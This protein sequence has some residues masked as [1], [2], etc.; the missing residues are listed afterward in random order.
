MSAPAGGPGGQPT[1]VDAPAPDT[2]LVS[3]S[4]VPPATTTDGPP[5][6]PAPAPAPGSFAVVAVVVAVAAYLTYGYLTM[7]VSE[8]SEGPGPRFFPGIVLV[9]AWGVAVGLAVDAVRAR[10][11]ARSGADRGEDEHPDGP[12][13]TDWRAVGTVTAVFAVFVVALVP[14]GWLLS[15][16]FLFWGVAQALGSRRRLF[17]AGVGLAISSVVQLVF[18]AVLGLGL[19]AGLLGVG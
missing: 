9:V 14:L 12:A 7:P 11:R 6:R 10:R 8:G 1:P 18:G 2:A 15:G 16:A 17:D 19:P 5:P 3:P 13:P 4:D